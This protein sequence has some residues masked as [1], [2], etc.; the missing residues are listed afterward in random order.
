MGSSLTNSN[1]RVRT[2]THGGV[3][4]ISGQPLP[5]CRSSRLHGNLNFKNEGPDYSCLVAICLRIVRPTN[6]YTLR[7]YSGVIVRG[8]VDLQVSGFAVLRQSEP[9]RM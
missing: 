3:A 6:A 4:G 5:L 9:R 7:R 1:R 2:R 8:T